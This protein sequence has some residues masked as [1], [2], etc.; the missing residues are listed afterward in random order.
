MASSGSGYHEEGVPYKFTAEAN[1][2]RQWRRKKGLDTNLNSNYTYAKSNK[3]AYRK[4]YD[5]IVWKRND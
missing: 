3:D 4:N 5:E 2:E 1:L